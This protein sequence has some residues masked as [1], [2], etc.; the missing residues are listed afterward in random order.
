MV[1]ASWEDIESQTSKQYHKKDQELCCYVRSR[2]IDTL[3]ET[4]DQNVSLIKEVLK[5]VIL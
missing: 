5:H 2:N 3:D 4:L 1:N